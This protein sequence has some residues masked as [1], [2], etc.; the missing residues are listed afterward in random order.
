MSAASKRSSRAP[1][2]VVLGGINT[3][4]VI[5]S[6]ELPR[7]GQTVH[8]EDLFIGAGGKG[9]N[10]AVAGARLGARVSLIG[11]V[12][13]EP[14]GR[15]LV[16]GL[17]REKIDIR[18]VSFTPRRPSGAA[19]I[20][21]E[22]GGEKQISSGPGANLALTP[23]Q[24]REAEE[25]IA[26]ADVLLMQFESPMDCVVAA[27]RIAREHGVKVVLDPAPPT[28]VP[29]ELFRMVYAIRPNS[30]E[31]EQMTGVAVKDKASARRAGEVLRKKGISVVALQAG[32]AGD[33][34]ISEEEEIFLPRLKVKTVDTTGA[35]DAFAA[36]LAV[37]IGE[38][39]SLR[40]A[41]RLAN[42]TAALSTTKAGAQAGMP[43][44]RQVEQMLR[45]GR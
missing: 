25:L 24:I 20:A 35:G 34:V 45:R 4:Y 26:K 42:V 6:K 9:A 40:A 16:T 18:F 44:R 41:A 15:D 11:R 5:R 12:G 31:A 23:K 2:I 30:D 3:D 28:R 33:L 36:G 1:R 19:I 21:V 39:L 32:E 27:A 22:A 17:L 7:A 8:G 13:D 37:G 14:R 10:Q 29:R 38:G 43:L